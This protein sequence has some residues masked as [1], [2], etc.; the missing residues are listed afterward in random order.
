MAPW[1]LHNNDFAY[2]D[3]GSGFV[4][5]DRK[6]WNS[7]IYVNAT[8]KNQV[9]LHNIKHMYVTESLEY[10]SDSNEAG[11]FMMNNA[12]IIQVGA[13]LLTPENVIF[14]NIDLTAHALNIESKGFT[15]LENHVDDATV[16]NIKTKMNLPET[17]EHQVRNGK[18]LE[19]DPIFGAM[20]KDHTVISI[21]RMLLE[22]EVKCATWSSN[23][24]YTENA[25]TY[26]PHWHVDYPYHDIPSSC[27]S[28]IPMSAQVLWL[29]DDFTVE[30]GGT[31]IVP[32]SHMFR[33]FPS[34]KNMHDKH[35]EIVQ[36]PKGSVVISHGAWWHSQ[37][38]NTTK[39][40]RTCLLGTYV[41]KWLASKDDMKS[42][43]NNAYAHTHVGNAGNADEELYNLL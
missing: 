37:G 3:I 39:E 22:N 5:A 35:I 9:T 43:Y 27:W 33:A 34:D 19:L 25:D 10:T 36:Y 24:L 20:L 23:T 11:K 40:S 18:L 2:L 14:N 32:G 4:S 38:C 26:K 1:F 41:Q 8:N 31:H 7:V 29:L 28:D 6:S 15:V 16:K 13:Y 12:G 21:V 42:Q 17:S 30:N